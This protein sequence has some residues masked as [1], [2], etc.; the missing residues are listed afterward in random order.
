MVV[1]LHCIV[2]SLHNDR[3]Y[4]HGGCSGIECG[5]CDVN[6]GWLLGDW[7]VKIG[8]V[9]SNAPSPWA[10]SLD[11][12]HHLLHIVIKRFHKHVVSGLNSA[13]DTRIVVL[14][15]SLLGSASH[16]IVVLKNSHMI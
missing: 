16:C 9:L 14:S 5:N 12:G 2:R 15:N 13:E 10:V 6:I 3:D 11:G 1:G 4:V 7:A 8:R